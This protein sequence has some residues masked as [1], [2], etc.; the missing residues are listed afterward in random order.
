MAF[1]ISSVAFNCIEVYRQIKKYFLSDS[2]FLVYH[3]STPH[4]SGN[5]DNFQWLNSEFHGFGLIFIIFKTN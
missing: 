4:Y 3:E 2:Y 1:Y 5:F